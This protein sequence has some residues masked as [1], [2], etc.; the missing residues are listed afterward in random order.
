MKNLDSTD[1]GAIQAIGEKWRELR[2]LEKVGV[3]AI[4]VGGAAVIAAVAL[5]SLASATMGGAL[6][7]AGA[8]LIRRGFGG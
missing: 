2:P 3:V 8:Y 7:G 1:K 4:G 6:G 5:P